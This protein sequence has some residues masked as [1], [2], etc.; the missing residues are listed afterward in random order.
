MVPQSKYFS[1]TENAS[2]L[3]GTSPVSRHAELN[4]QKATLRTPG[5]LSSKMQRMNLSTQ[6]IS[7]YNYVNAEDKD[8]IA[9]LFP[10]DSVLQGC[11]LSGAWL[12]S[13][14][15]QRRIFKIFFTSELHHR[16]AY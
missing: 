10:S 11:S 5:R 8:P 6:E 15:A 1:K 16:Q 3:L 7:Y 2:E 14:C 12:L 4:R 13:I 9:P